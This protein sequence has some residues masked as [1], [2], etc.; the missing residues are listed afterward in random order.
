ME[1]K[2]VLDLNAPPFSP[3]I[4]E[5]YENVGELIHVTIVFKSGWE[6]RGVMTKGSLVK[7][8]RDTTLCIDNHNNTLFTLEIPKEDK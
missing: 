7:T 3:I 5:V 4:E 8:S 6:F 2:V 1:K